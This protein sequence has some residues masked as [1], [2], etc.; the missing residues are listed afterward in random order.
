MFYVNSDYYNWLLEKVDCKEYPV[1]QYSILLKQMFTTDYIW[2]LPMDENRAKDGINLRYRFI[3]E[4]NLGVENK[5]IIDNTPCNILELMVALSLRCEEDIMKDEDIGN[6][7]SDWFW[8][9]V[10]SLGM[11]LFL[12]NKYGT[13]YDR[14]IIF[15]I[16][17]NF[18]TRKYDPDGFGSLFTVKGS[19][20]MRDKEIWYQMHE[21]LATL[22]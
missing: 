18:M 12:D 3:Y 8:G 11:I 6:R 7:T 16:L 15:K 9:M 17:E 19:T 20:D 10:K 2:E 1:S 4:K 22:I 14:K 13:R 5:E 21:Y